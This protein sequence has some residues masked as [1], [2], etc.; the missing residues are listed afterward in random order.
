M[1]VDANRPNVCAVVERQGRYV[2]AGAPN[3]GRNATGG[4]QR[5]SFASQAQR[6]EPRCEVSYTSHI[7]RFTAQIPRAL[8][9]TSPRAVTKLGLFLDPNIRRLYAAPCVSA[10]HPSRVHNVLD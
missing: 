7:L 6:R 9:C 2:G 4:A 1:M 8:Q 3:A 10:F 5:A